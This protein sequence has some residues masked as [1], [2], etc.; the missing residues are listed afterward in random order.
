LTAGG[1]L[2]FHVLG[3]LAEFERNVIREATPPW[4]PCG[5]GA[6]TDRGRPKT[7]ADPKTLALAR[8]LY[9]DGRADVASICRTLDTARS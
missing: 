9:A 5:A 1:K 2:V 7:L 4:A 6:G 3:A 8:T